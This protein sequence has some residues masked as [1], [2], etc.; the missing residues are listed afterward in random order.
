M[1]IKKIFTIAIVTALFWGCSGKDAVSEYDKPALYWY[2][3]IVKEIASSN[4]DRADNYYISLRSEHARSPLLPTAT[5]LLAQIHM[6]EQ[7][8]IMADYYLDEYLKKYASGARIEQAKFLKIKAAFLGVTNI[9]RDQKLMIDT[10]GEVDKF[11]ATYPNS[12]YLP[13]VKTVQVRLNMAQYLM[14][15]N[16][17]NLYERLD[18]GKAAKIY[19]QKNA[20]S[21]LNTADIKAPAIGFFDRIFN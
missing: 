3:N 18:K 1:N 11:V 5:M 15:E 7:E 12:I 9:N 10:L 19:H 13:V 17:S 21:P 14:N 2:K 16:I 8:Y 4:L 6:D 20:S